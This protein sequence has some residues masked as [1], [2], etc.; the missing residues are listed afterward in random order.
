[1]GL[2]VWFIMLNIYTMSYCND[3]LFLKDVN[4]C[5]TKLIKYIQNTLAEVCYDPDLSIWVDFFQ[6][7]VL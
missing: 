3:N 4:T 1:M 2:C 6:P 5:Q 7:D